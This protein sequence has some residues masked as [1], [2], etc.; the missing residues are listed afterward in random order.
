MVSKSFLNT[1]NVSSR[2]GEVLTLTI[3]LQIFC[4]FK[5]HFSRKKADLIDGK[6]QCMAR[7]GDAN[8][9]VACL[10]V[11]RSFIAFVNL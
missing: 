7:N 2:F 4:E 3:Y 5:T 11:V 10:V 1:V 6:R 8:D 9:F